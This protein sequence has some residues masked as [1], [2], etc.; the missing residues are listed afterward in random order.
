MF[1]ASNTF[2]ERTQGDAHMQT[3]ST[4]QATVYL[5]CL[6]SV[7]LSQLQ[8][9]GVMNSVSLERLLGFKGANLSFDPIREREAICFLC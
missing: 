2:P 1:P 4:G 8:A 5:P 7:I 9:E 3:N 6:L